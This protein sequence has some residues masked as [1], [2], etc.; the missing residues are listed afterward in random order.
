MLAHA[1]IS[2]SCIIAFLITFIIVR[3]D[4]CFGGRATQFCDCACYLGLFV[5]DNCTGMKYTVT[6]IVF[7][8]HFLHRVTI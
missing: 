6:A 1:T 3:D 7:I 5:G 2:Y 4:G 8:E